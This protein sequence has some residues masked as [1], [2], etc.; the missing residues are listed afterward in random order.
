M[1]LT[2]APGGDQVAEYLQ[3]NREEMVSDLRRFVGQE[4]PSGDPKLLAT[5]A[6]FLCEYACTVGDGRG[7]IL[8]GE[9]GGFHVRVTYGT[10]SGD[11]RP[12]M[13]LGHFDTVWP[14]GTLERMPFRLDDGM[15]Y[16]PG[17]FDM[18]GGLV[19]GLWA[20]RAVAE[21]GGVLP[22]MV[23]LCNCDEEIGSPTSREL[24]QDQARQSA[25]VLVLEPSMDGSLKTARKGVGRYTIEVQ[26]RAAH[27]GLD[28]NSGV[29]AI[30][31]ISRMVLDLHD[32][33]DEDR[34]AGTSVNV[35]VITGGTAF[36]VIPS[37]AKAHVDVRVSTVVESNRVAEA[38]AAL[39]P[40]HEGADVRVEGG[41]I[42]PPMERTDKTAVLV[43]YAQDI[44]QSL[45]FTLGE[46]NVG[47]A[48]D[49]NF[50]A[51]VGAAV[52]D[53]LGAV[54]AGAHADNEHVDIAAM[55]LRA[56]LVAHAIRGFGS[57]ATD[58]AEAN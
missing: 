29:S 3:D 42:W 49:G 35:G 22:P 16:G 31:E 30:D 8:R 41:L 44:A 43:R 12:L 32:L 38:I 40:R 15:A 1:S 27:A 20:I 50:C 5:F 33:S 51:A 21:A 2:G 55:P 56:A 11:S 9:G 6:E 28:P 45:G 36:N 48:S 4:T 46:R 13:L 47:G 19:Q 7:E 14:A 24:I 58:L 25:A 26:G 39:R 57:I 52:L 34:M 53:G 54:G 23:L 18:K 37:Q 10:P 17:A